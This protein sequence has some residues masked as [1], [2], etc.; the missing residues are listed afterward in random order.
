MTWNISET[1]IAFRSSICGTMRRRIPSILINKLHLF[2]LF[3]ALFFSPLSLSPLPLNSPTMTGRNFEV[4]EITTK[5]EFA[6]LNDVL[7]TANFHPYEWVSYVHNIY[8]NPRI[9]PTLPLD[10]PSS[11]ST[12]SMAMHQRTAPK[13]RP[14][15]QTFNGPNTSRHVVLTTST[16]LKGRQAES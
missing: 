14:Q 3:L 16:P 5:E 2:A 10:L 8:D 7:W 1:Q 6:R 15:T 12:P 9:N 11:F 13:T 4:R